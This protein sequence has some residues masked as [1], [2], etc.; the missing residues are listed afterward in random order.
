M[1]LNSLGAIWGN[2]E[3]HQRHL[4][5]NKISRTGNQVGINGIPHVLVGQINSQTG[6]ESDKTGAILKREQI[7]NT[8]DFLI[9]EQK[10]ALVQNTGLKPWEP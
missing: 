4:V 6:K 3:G 5:G 10:S 8:I 9:G 1:V 7:Q 2:T